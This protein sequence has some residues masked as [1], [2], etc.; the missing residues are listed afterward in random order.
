[1]LDDGIQPY[2]ALVVESQ[3]SC[4]QLSGN[5]TIGSNSC[6]GKEAC[7]NSLA[8][9]TIKI[10]DESCLGNNACK[11]M[12]GSVLVGSTA[13][14][15][16]RS[17][18]KNQGDIG[19]GSCD[20]KKTC[21][22]NE[23]TIGNCLCHD[24][25][26]C[27]DNTALDYDGCS[28]PADGVDIGNVG[29]AGSSTIVDN[30]NGLVEVKAA[31][32]D[33]WHTTDSFHFFE[34]AAHGDFSIEFLVKDF[35]GSGLYEWAKAGLMLRD[36]LHENSEHFSIFV[37]GNNGLAN[38]W[39]TTDGGLTYNYNVSPQRNVCKIRYNGPFNLPIYSCEYEIQRKPRDVWLKIL[40]I[41]NTVRAYYKWDDWY[42][43]F[44]YYRHFR[45]QTM[46]FSGTFFYGIAVTSH[47]IKLTA[48]LSGSGFKFHP[49]QN[50]KDNALYIASLETE[51]CFPSA[52]KVKLHGLLN[53]LEIIQDFEFHVTSFG[54]NVADGKV[55]S[56]P[57]V[58]DK[59]FEASTEVGRDLS[60]TSSIKGSF[61]LEVDLGESYPIDSVVIVG[62]SCMDDLNCLCKLNG[63]TLSIIGD[64]GEEVTSMN[65]GNDA[66]GKSML[67]YVFDMAPEFCLPESVKQNVGSPQFQRRE[68]EPRPYGHRQLRK[69]PTQW[70][71]MHGLMGSF[72]SCA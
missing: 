5:V 37:T 6:Y 33:I 65:I 19:S 2:A 7:S 11:L 50:V 68:V 4:A 25:N 27:E 59:I 16:R 30:K 36:S 22:R 62:R 69:K 46:S 20:N 35:T 54:V 28:L 70:N 53:S 17:C 32:K 29:I 18:M 58:T 21:I 3:S 49:I 55:V 13:C 57:F 63:V 47:D 48:K 40:K 42:N 23:A 43:G 9:S 15:G 71:M 45:S 38:Q 14:I 12:E 72:L 52:R 60:T 51:S 44:P 56:K 8:L 1:M 67:E 31:G 41:G 34:K 10:S 61:G 66:C 26:E 24:Q 64:S 39:R